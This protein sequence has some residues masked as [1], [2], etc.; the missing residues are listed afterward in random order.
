M[1]KILLPLT[2]F[3]SLFGEAQ[4]ITLTAT[5]KQIAID[6]LAAN[7]NRIYV[8]PDKGK[9]MADFIQANLKQGKYNSITNPNNFADQVTSDILSVSNDKHLRFVYGPERVKNLLQDRNAPAPDIAQVKKEMSRDN[10]EEVKILPGNIGYIKFNGFVE[11]SI[12]GD[13]AA[14]TMNFVANTNAIIFDLRQNGGGSPSMI[15]LLTTYLYSEDQPVHLNNFYYRAENSTRQ[16]WTLPYVPGQRNP[17]A[18]VYVLTSE[19]TFSAAEEFTYN[20]KNLKRATIVGE[21]TGGGA[22]PGGMHPIGSNFLCFIPEGR[23]INPITNT[24]WEGTGVEPHIKV[25]QDLALY[26]AHEK[27]LDSLMK[28]TSSEQEKQMFKWHSDAVKAKSNPYKTDLKTVQSHTGKFGFRSLLF[29]KNALYYQREGR[30]KYMMTA[31]SNDYYLVEDLDIRVKII[32]ANKSV[33]AIEIQFP[34]GSVDRNEKN[35]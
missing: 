4:E 28:S 3:S 10:F 7:L 14:A 30:P 1:K 34:D 17:K 20:L 23:A 29:E 12:A 15:Q 35:K 18:Q 16:T 26:K 19:G 21:T 5:D 27:A 25:N 9:S 31:L 11:A 2:L 24:N 33:V 32:S 22:H 8:F 6:S 13:A